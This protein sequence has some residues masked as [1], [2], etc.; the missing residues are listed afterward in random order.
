[1]PA[2]AARPAASSSARPSTTCKQAA[3]GDARH[4]AWRPTSR[5]A[6]RCRSNCVLVTRGHRH[7]QGAVPLGAG[8]PRHARRSPSSPPRD[9]GVDIEQ[10]ARENPEDDP[11]ACT[12]ISSQGLQPYQCRELGFGMGLNAKQVNQLTKIM[13]GLYKLFNEKDLALVELNP[14]A[15]LDRR[16]PRRRSTA[17]ST[18]TT[19]PTFRH[20]DLAAMRDIR[21]E[22]ATE[23]ARQ[24]ARPQLRD[25]GRQHRLHGQRR[26]PGDGDDGRDQAQRR[27]AGELPR[28][29]RR[30]DQGARDRGVQADPVLATRCARSSSTSSAA[31]CA[32]T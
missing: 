17:R 25:H 2:A 1:M 14:L 29:R 24:P 32:A 19:T 9:G 11:D 15:I 12:W 5:P 3:S 20:P 28:R 6:S 13:L 7:R 21:Q 30:R 4:A 10:V 23:A 27:R 18:P 16:R 8:R 31:S 22:D 26:G